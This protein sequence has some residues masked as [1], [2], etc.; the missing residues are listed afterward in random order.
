M[1]TV[2]GRTRFQNKEATGPC[3][4]EAVAA[5]RRALVIPVISNGGV[6]SHADLLRCLE[7]TGAAGVMSSEA[8]LENPA[9]FCGNFDAGGAYVDQDRLA[10][11]YLDLAEMYLPGAGSADECPKCVK[12]HVFKLVYAGLQDNHDL[13][14][15]VGSARSL[16]EFR[17]VVEESCRRGAGRSPCTTLA[18]SSSQAGVVLPAPAPRR[19]AERRGGGPGAAQRHAGG[20]GGP[21]TRRGRLRASSTDAAAPV[22]GSL[23][24]LLSALILRFLCWFPSPSPPPQPPDHP[25]GAR[26][27]CLGFVMGPFSSAPD[28]ASTRTFV[29]V[30]SAIAVAARR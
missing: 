13:R 9:I 29:H 26:I 4:L 30:T 19:G 14:D 20:A 28:S 22:L 7:V 2:H 21:R 16:P 1:L 11:E 15:R 23:L 5:I 27:G 3:D 17:A 6:A 8:A 12:A 24:V 10:R 25:K 18:R